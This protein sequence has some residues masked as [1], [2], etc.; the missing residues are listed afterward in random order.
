MPVQARRRVLIVRD[1]HASD[2][3]LDQQLR[4]PG[5]QVHSAQGV[6]SGCAMLRT[7]D[8]AVVVANLDIPDERALAIIRAA[9][10][11]R[12]QGAH[13]GRAPALSECII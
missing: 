1:E 5:V 13:V 11:G 8:F 6:A 4:V 3:A 2:D 10:R 7:H 9:G 12:G